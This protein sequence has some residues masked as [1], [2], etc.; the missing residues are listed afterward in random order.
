MNK[1]DFSKPISDIETV[2]EGCK[3]SLAKSDW[4]CMSLYQILSESFIEKFEDK[5]HWYCI[6]K[7]QT[8]SE[9]FIEK[10]KDKIDWYCI[11]A[12]QTL[13]ERFIEKWK[14]EVN[15]DCLLNNKNIHW[16]EFSEEFFDRYN[17]YLNLKEIHKRRSFSKQF[18]LKYNLDYRWS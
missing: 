5:V 3:D 11:S 13:S 12:W 4:L 10:W 7:Y 1:P 9:P 17:E 18:C 14:Y 6:S 16:H 15:W 2:V 8:L